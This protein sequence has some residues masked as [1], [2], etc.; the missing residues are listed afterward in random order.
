MELDAPMTGVQ[1][2]TAPSN[3]QEHQLPANEFPTNEPIVHELHAYDH[4]PSFVT[5][6][7]APEDGLNINQEQPATSTGLSS[8]NT[9]VIPPPV[10]LLPVSQPQAIQPPVFQPPV[11]QSPVSE[12]PTNEHVLA[13]VPVSQYNNPISQ[14][15]ASINGW[16]NNQGQPA[17]SIGLP[18]QSPNVASPMQIKANVLQSIAY[19]PPT[20]G[21]MPIPQ[22]VTQHQAPLGGLSNSQNQPATSMGLSSQSPPVIPPVKSQPLTLESLVYHPPQ[23]GYMPISVTPYQM[24][25]GEDASSDSAWDI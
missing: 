9:K 11:F 5:Q 14:T 22:P 6:H 8:Q 15:E 25:M 7:Q 20:S 10:Q 1:E 16:S 17:T 23:Q 3:S 2:P 12:L 21:S 13:T 4:F 19:V 24:P 18:S